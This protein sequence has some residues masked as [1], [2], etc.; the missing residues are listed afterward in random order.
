MI[1]SLTEKHLSLPVNQVKLVFTG[2][3]RI[4]K[5]TLKK[6]LMK[7][8]GNLTTHPDHSPSTGVGKP[9]V[10]CVRCTRRDKPQEEEYVGYTAFG[11]PPPGSP[12]DASS[13][14]WKELDLSKLISILLE[15]IHGLPKHE[16]QAPQ[17]IVTHPTT[18]NS[19]AKEGRNEK[20]DQP[21][22][23]SSSL[24]SD[25]H[26]KESSPLP[27]KV[28]N[29][30][31]PSGSTQPKKTAPVPHPELHETV[32]DVASEINWENVREQLQPLVKGT[33]VYVMDTGGQPEF[34]EVLPHV[35]KGPA[36]HLVLFSL[37]EGKDCLDRCFKVEHLSEDLKSGIPYKSVCPVSEIL[38]QLLASFYSIHKTQEI[39]QDSHHVHVC[40]K[41]LKPSVIKPQAVLIGT[42]KDLLVTQSEPTT[43]E[44]TLE[45]STPKEERSEKADQPL[46]SSS[47]LPSVAKVSSPLLAKVERTRSPSGSAQPKNAASIPQHEL[48][49]SINEKLVTAFAKADFV[50]KD[51]LAVPHE[52]WS[53]DT[54]QVFGSDGALFLAVDNMHGTEEEMTELRSFLSTRISDIAEPVEL[55]CSV[56]LFH[57]LLR[58][59]FEKDRGYCEIGECEELATMCQIPRNDVK[60][61][62]K[63]LHRTLGTIL[64]YEDVESLK[65]TVFCN[66]NLLLNQITQLIA[67]CF[68]CNPVMKNSTQKARDTGIIECELLDYVL[69]S[70]KKNSIISRKKVIDFLKHHK[71]VMEIGGGK[72]GKGKKKLFMPCLMRPKPD[73]ADISKQ[74]FDSFDVEPLLIQFPGKIIPVGL[75]TSLVVQLCQNKWKNGAPWNLDE[76]IDADKKPRYRNQ[77]TFRIRESFLCLTLTAKPRFIEVLVEKCACSSKKEPQEFFSGVRDHVIKAIED[78]E[79][80]C[81]PIVGFYCPKG[82][83]LKKP[84]AHFAEIEGE[85]VL[86]CSLCCSKCDS[87]NRGRIW[88]PEKVSIV[89]I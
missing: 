71:L 53:Q 76:N 52:L 32:K 68:T 88:F 54:Q 35:L 84:D 34:Q 83:Q 43:E 56:L 80:Q 20:A 66:P 1:K 72:D 38:F 78:T 29:T 57:L 12:G 64:Y 10:V 24:P 16:Q 63:Y 67:T 85:D 23:S 8:I 37:E 42:H 74:A 7:K 65:D 36:L 69:R 82:F 4:G 50:Q 77:V 70:S 5:T 33:S 44:L 14:E 89:F 55:P 46:E 3:P 6:R 17:V 87:P 75:F 58:H 30:L 73:I 81:D 59:Q 9:E 39:T 48:F 45:S 49:G 40:G 11:I 47:S 18:E 25:V 28:E 86:Q 22:E 19:P 62:L 15:N 21:L 41:P 31:S 51:F 13:L 26:V 60:K 79:L 2:P 27:E 61:V